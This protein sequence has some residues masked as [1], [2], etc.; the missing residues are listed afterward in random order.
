[1]RKITEKATSS[2][3]NNQN[4]RLNNTEVEVV[5]DETRLLLHGNLI[6]KK[7]N[8]ILYISNCGWFSNTT[9]ERLNALPNVSIS[10]KNYEWYL[11][12]K[13]WDGKLIKL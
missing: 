10:Q 13:Y 7:V 3:L 9:K 4:F 2:F 8:G 11:N 1:M 12:G 6:A 5:G